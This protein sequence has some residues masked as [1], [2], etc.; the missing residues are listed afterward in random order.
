MP[1]SKQIPGL[2]GPTI[3]AM[4]MSQIPLVQLH[5][6]DAQIPPWSTSQVFCVCSGPRY[7]PGAQS[8]GA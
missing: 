3:I 1:N 5:L 6:Y 7:R 2:V 8:L 4:V